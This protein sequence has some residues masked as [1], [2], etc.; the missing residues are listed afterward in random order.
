[1]ILV[2]LSAGASLGFLT[3]V[4]D[5]FW[6]LSRRVSKW[7]SQSIS[8]LL[9]PVPEKVLNRRAFLVLDLTWTG[10]ACSLTDGALTPFP[11]DSLSYHDWEG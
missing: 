7:F 4:F 5:K 11:I 9:S 2:R 8:A 10:S 1:M 6:V 3:T